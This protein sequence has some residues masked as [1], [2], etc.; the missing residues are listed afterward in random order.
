MMKELDEEK[1]MGPDE[2]TCAPRLR[3]MRLLLGEEWYSRHTPPRPKGGAR[4]WGVRSIHPSLNSLAEEDRCL[5]RSVGVSLEAWG[6]VVEPGG[7]ERV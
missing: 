3:P 2:N 4:P 7:Q 6:W 5:Y 1:A